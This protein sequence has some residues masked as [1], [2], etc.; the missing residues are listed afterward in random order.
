M[1]VGVGV[2][3]S[4]GVGEGVE[5]G[6]DVGEGVGVRDSMAATAAAVRASAVS[7]AAIEAT[8]PPSSR[9]GCHVRPPQNT[10][11][12]IGFR[13]GI[14]RYTGEPPPSSSRWSR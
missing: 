8:E 2:G 7:W 13:H 1:K 14:A 11:Q 6:V 4:V 5:V 9:P 10:C 3:V 12:A